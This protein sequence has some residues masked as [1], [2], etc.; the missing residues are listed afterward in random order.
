MGWT[1][2]NVLVPIFAPL[3]VLLFF[4]LFPL[5]ASTRRYLRWTTP[6]KDGQVAWVALAFNAASAYDLMSAKEEV[7]GRGWVLGGLIV[8]TVANV[9]IAGLGGVFPVDSEPPEGTS[10]WRHYRAM[11]VSAWLTLLSAFMFIGVHFLA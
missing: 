5:P 4:R 2:V 11:S 6:I 3:L 9:L 1:I 7:V 8:L 10:P